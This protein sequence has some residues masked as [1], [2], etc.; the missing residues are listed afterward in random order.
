MARRKESLDKIPSDDMSAATPRFER[1]GGNSRCRAKGVQDDEAGFRIR[2][3]F[4]RVKRRFGH[5]PLSTR[6]RAHDPN[7]LDLSERMSRH[8]AAI[9]HVPAK[10]KELVQLKVAALVGCPF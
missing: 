5:I 2:R 3:I 9:G 10:L 7:L 6:I 1:T 8:T 4:R